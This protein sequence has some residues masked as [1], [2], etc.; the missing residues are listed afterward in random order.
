MIPEDQEDSSLELRVE[1]LTLASTRA[2]FYLTRCQ[3]Q[4]HLLKCP[5]DNF[6][7]CTLSGRTFSEACRIPRVKT[8]ISLVHRDRKT[9]NSLERTFSAPD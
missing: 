6:D 4:A 3:P 8:W 7:L 1:V 9:P 2:R 5:V